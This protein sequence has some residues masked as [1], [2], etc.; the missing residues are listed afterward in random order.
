MKLS[1]FWR[2]EGLGGTSGRKNGSPPSRWPVLHGV[3]D[4][5]GHEWSAMPPLMVLTIFL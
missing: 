3:G 1:C 2:D 5:I 4:D